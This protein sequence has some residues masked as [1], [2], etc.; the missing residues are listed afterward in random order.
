MI[1]VKLMGG[2][3]NQMFQY[4]IGR[5]MSLKNR[6]NLALDLTFY[7]NQTDD[8]TPRH[9]EL[10]CFKLKP[11]L[12][13][14]EAPTRKGILKIISKQPF[15]NTYNEKHFHFDPTA[16]DQPD[17]TVFNGYWQTDK[18]FSD[19]RKELLDDFTITTPLSIDDQKVFDDITNETS[20]SLHVRR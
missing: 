15:T 20:V 16:L 9:Y 12:I 1:G 11:K 8:I 18:Y 7:S 3:G 4:A 14:K 13:T 5:K 2:L 10:G 17:G 6:T 19:I